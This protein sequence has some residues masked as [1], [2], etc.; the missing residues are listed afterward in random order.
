MKSGARRRAG[1]LARARFAEKIDQNALN[2]HERVQ[3]ILIL[4]FQCI[5][6]YADDCDNQLLHLGDVKYV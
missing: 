3:K 4:T 6:T 1:A 2:M 5:W